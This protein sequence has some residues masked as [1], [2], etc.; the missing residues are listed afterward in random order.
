MNRDDDVVPIT[1]N[2][3]HSD[4]KP[5]NAEMQQ[6]IIHE[7]NSI[8]RTTDRSDKSDK[9]DKSDRSDKHRDVVI[10]VKPDVKP[11]DKHVDKPVGKPVDTPVDTPVDKPIDAV[12]EKDTSFMGML[13]RHRMTI[14]A[15]L[16]VLV[17]LIIVYYLF[18]IKDAK[19]EPEKPKPGI[20]KQGNHKHPPQQK[21]L[22]HED[23][24]NSV[25]N[26]E[27][28]AVLNMEK[29]MQNKGSLIEQLHAK[30]MNAKNDNKSDVKSQIS[31]KV[32]TDVN[33]GDR[34][35]VKTNV[36]A[37][38]SSGVKTNVNADRSSGIRQASVPDVKSQI[39]SKFDT[40]VKP[41]VKSDVPDVKSQISSKFDT[42]VKPD[43]KS[44][45]P[46]V[47][48]QIPSKFDTDVKTDDAE[49]K[50]RIVDDRGVTS[51]VD[52]DDNSLDD[53][54]EYSGSYEDY[55]SSEYTSSDE[56]KPKI[57]EVKAK[58]KKADDYVEK[59]IGENIETH[60]V[61]DDVKLLN[62][63]SVVKPTVRNPELDKLCEHVLDNL[64]GRTCKKLRKAGEKYCA[65]HIDKHV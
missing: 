50:T 5:K 20:P 56:H 11:A 51:D 52:D 58:N 16:I 29:A 30:K 9:Y 45:V 61:A 44:D 48:S 64:S 59:L 3:R 27:I 41:D 13:Y 46:D 32:D 34:S 31:S 35:G 2:L 15:I 53:D 60:S 4:F 18:C 14:I 7:G 49:K 39:S 19:T 24:V 26:D 37:D 42:D 38:L 10:D 36:N 65:M 54:I 8:K 12:P 25:S 33:A 21:M 62:E 1:P 47:K 55:S 63:T 17:I 23:L 28:N 22:Q 57:Y 43:V 40:D 6:R